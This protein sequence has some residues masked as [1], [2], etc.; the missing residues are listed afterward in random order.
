MVTSHATITS[1]NNCLET[2]DSA[3]CGAGGRKGIAPG[4][5]RDRRAGAAASGH[6]RSRGSR[7]RTVGWGLRGTPAAYCR[8][9]LSAR[10]LNQLQLDSA[11]AGQV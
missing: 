1:G 2:N 10:P 9:A 3:T 11:E 8:T 6:G 5:A 4:K 7:Q